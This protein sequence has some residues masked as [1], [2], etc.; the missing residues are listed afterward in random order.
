M[1]TTIIDIP[2]LGKM[3]HLDEEQIVALVEVFLL[4]TVNF[5]PVSVD[6]HMGSLKSALRRNVGITKTSDFLDVTEAD[7]P[8]LTTEAVELVM[9]GRF[10]S[11]AVA[12]TK[13]VIDE[14]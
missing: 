9:S 7:L 2:Y 13:A 12:G 10:Y 1:A 11:I 8:E 6:R 5:P 3:K 4:H 14:R